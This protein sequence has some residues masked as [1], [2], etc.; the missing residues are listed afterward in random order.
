MMK[1]NT[2]EHLL[3]TDAQCL[4]HQILL[5]K[6]WHVR[7][8]PAKHTFDYPYR[9]W[10]LSLKR[11]V[12]GDMPTE[13]GLFKWLG[14][15]ISVRGR[16][17]HH[18]DFS[19]Y[20]DIAKL[21]DNNQ[22]HDA[23]KTDT[24]YKTDVA[25]KYQAKNA[26]STQA[27]AKVWLQQVHK[28][29]KQLTGSVPTGDV[30]AL[31]VGRNLG[32]YFSPVNFYIG[33]DDVGNASHL[34]AEVSNTPWNKRHFYGFTLAGNSSEFSH[35]KNFHVSP[36]NPVNQTYTWRVNIKD[37]DKNT[38][39]GIGL[40]DIDLS[41]SVSDERGKIFVAGINMQSMVMSQQNLRHTVFKN[42]IM[43]YSSIGRIYWHAFLLYA[44]KKV[45]YVD[46]NQKLKDSK[47]K[48]TY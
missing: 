1:T 36:F 3:L 25:A 47:Q 14:K 20:F 26:G 24:Q 37:S 32:F 22:T 40:K 23:Y 17:V 31:V 4:P 21:D 15:P 41:I 33:F 35:N 11:L 2:K 16:A 42:P 43:N 18:F 8:T 34:L 48:N 27:K 45:P 29:F 12:Q 13:I 39:T 9:Y 19:D 7:Y 28:A 6:T 46:Y 30:L 5:G 10:G 44:M 38:G